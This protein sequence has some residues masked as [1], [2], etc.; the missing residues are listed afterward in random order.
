M[1]MLTYPDTRFKPIARSSAGRD[2]A[3][4]A[5]IDARRATLKRICLHIFVGLLAGGA[6]AAVMALKTA[7]YFWRF[8]I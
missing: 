8:P 6:L 3:N 2:T 7:A 4:A 5:A 1:A